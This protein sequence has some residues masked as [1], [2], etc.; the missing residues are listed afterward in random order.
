[1]TKLECS[2]KIKQRHYLVLLEVI[3]WNKMRLIFKIREKFGRFYKIL[4]VVLVLLLLIGMLGIT[5]YNGNQKV[6][7]GL[8][9]YELAVKYGYDGTVQ[10]WLTSLSGK[11]AYEIAVDNGYKGTEKEWIESLKASSNEV[12]SVKTAKFSS[13]GDLLIVLSDDSEINL[14]KAVGKDG[15]N[16]SNGKMVRMVKWNRRKERYKRSERK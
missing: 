2:C 1:M 14:G 4:C 5:V 16:G 10:D 6:E 3:L 7:N 8:S 11:S 13:N 9:A 12:V 15:M